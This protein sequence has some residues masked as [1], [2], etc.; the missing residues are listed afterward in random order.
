MLDT[1]PYADLLAIYN[2]I[3]DKPVTRFDTRANG[4]RRT[5]A[6]LEARSLSIPEAAQLADVVLSDGNHSQEK[7]SAT[8]ARVALPGDS[9]GPSE[10]EVA[11]DPSV[12]P[13]G[14]GPTSILVDP[15]IS[16]SVEAFVRE[17]MKPA[18][19]A[20][21]TAFLRRLNTGGA[22][23][24]RTT[25]KR[26]GDMTPSQRKIVDLCCRLEGAT[27]KE[28]AEGCGWPSIAART[29]CQKLADRFGYDLHESP[30]ANGRGISFRMTVK[31]AAEEQV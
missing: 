23:S 18:R 9:D 27:G 31:P 12:E 20:Y 14:D 29:T 24:A 7:T 3:S 25:T 1:M 5:E 21:I 19:P 10:H 26:E 17:L 28:L 13:A 22:A 16:S 6:L 11:A 8:N 4:V 15:G 2:A 30:K